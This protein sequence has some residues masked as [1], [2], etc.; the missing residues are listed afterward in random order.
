MALT[1]EYVLG[2]NL[3]VW[4]DGVGVGH[5]DSCSLKFSVD[6]KELSDKD[7]DP[8]ATTPGAVNIIL[9]KKR[10]SLTSSGYVW[11]SDT[12]VSAATGG[13]RTL[14]TKAINGTQVTWRFDT[15]VTGD[16][17][18]T[19]DGYITEFGASGDDASEAKYNIVVDGT[20]SFTFG[21]V[22]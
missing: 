10:V 2:H 5:A 7:T 13:Y 18:W 12:G 6:K 22:S 9:G 15:D 11:E 3:R 20:G 14:G 1:S 16:S 8:G 21:T 17:S 4:I 19:G